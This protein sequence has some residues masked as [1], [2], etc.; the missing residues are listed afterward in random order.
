MKNSLHWFRHRFTLQRR[1]FSQAEE[2]IRVTNLRLL[3][4]ASVLEVIFLVFFICFTP[5]L[6]RYWRPTLPYFLFLGFALLTMTAVLILR[7][8][9]KITSRLTNLLCSLFY[10]A[11]LAGCLVI[12]IFPNTSVHSTYFAVIMVT[13]PAILVLPFWIEFPITLVMEI[14]FT[15]IDL[16]CKEPVIAKQDAYQSLVAF[17]CSLVVMFIVVSLHAREGLL[18]YHYIRKGTIDPL[19]HISN[20]GECEARIRDALR[21]RQ[22]G[23]QP[24]AL[25]MFDIDGFKQIND[26][27]GHQTGD[28]VLEQ[29]GYILGTGFRGDD[30]AGRI[31]GDE[32]MVLL[33][34]IR[35]DKS[36]RELASRIEN[37]ISSL[38]TESAQFR[39]SC[40]LGIARLKGSASYEDMYHAADTAMYVAKRAGA[41]KYVIFNVE[42]LPSGELEIVQDDNAVSPA[43]ADC[44]T[45]KP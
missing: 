2:E 21:L 39:I 28:H 5:F 32:F 24:C 22:P 8:S 26:Q 36:L 29:V 31:G 45:G 4:Y 43:D 12:D 27:H 30:I 10:T 40:S 16:S 33:K 1:Y 19:T 14:L 13:L 3:T 9:P 20:R 38:T 23:D 6:F 11:T 34:A 35:D 25:L 37:S 7:N 18:K 42:E 44:S 17:L 15:A 41:G